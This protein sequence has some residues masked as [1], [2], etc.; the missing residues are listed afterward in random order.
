MVPCRHAVP[1]ILSLSAEFGS[2]MDGVKNMTNVL[3]MHLKVWVDFTSYHGFLFYV[4]LILL[5]SLEDCL[6]S[7]SH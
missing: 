1:W 4:I 7:Y 5:L 3:K 6:D 2:V